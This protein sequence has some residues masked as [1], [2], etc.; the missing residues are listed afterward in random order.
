MMDS[1][2]FPLSRYLARVGLKAAPDLNERGL[3]QVHLAQALSIPFENFDIHL[4]RTVSL[5]PKDLAAK[6]IQQG[7][8]GYCFEL[9]GLL[10]LALKSLG[11]AVRPLLARV[12]Y[13]RPDAGARTH[14]VL[15]VAISGRKWLADDGFGG[16]GLREPIPLVPDQ[17]EEQWGELYRLRRDS[18]YGMVLQKKAGDAFID[19]YAFDEEEVTLDIDIEMANHFTSTWPESIFR[20]Q[21]MC[22]LQTTRGRITL[23]DMELTIH[24]DGKIKNRTLPPGPGYIEALEK[25][26]G[27][28]LAA[29]YE[30]L[31]PLRPICP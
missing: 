19:L 6:L 16:P 5:N 30:D 23:T 24:R 12:L 29:R 13:R 3:R 4:G 25:Y 7:R 9:N 26:F 15:I 14:E 20:L 17:I 18:R 27:I 31:S 1:T 22:A 2:D 21:R 11:F 10:H 8:G 28:R